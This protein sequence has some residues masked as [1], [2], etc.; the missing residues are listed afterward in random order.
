LTGFLVDYV[1]TRSLGSFLIATPQGHILINSD[2]ERN[3]PTVRG[4]IE[5]LGCVQIGARATERLTE[6]GLRAKRAEGWG[7]CR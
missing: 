5:Q 3:V 6:I 4:S 1:G 7:L 2:Y